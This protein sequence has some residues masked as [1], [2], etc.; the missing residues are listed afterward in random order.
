MSAEISYFGELFTGNKVTPAITKAANVAKTFG[1]ALV[2]ARTPV[3]TGELKS[4]WKAK[5]EGNG[6]RWLND[7]PY[8]GFVEL[9]TRKMA[10]RQMLTSSLIDIS[11]VFE[12]ELAKELGRTLGASVIAEMVGT[13]DQPT[14]GNRV[15]DNVPGGFS[16]RRGF[17]PKT[18]L[19]RKQKDIIGAAKPLLRRGGRP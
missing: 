2:S 1:L 9:G 12:Q 7:T 15:S 19:T 13:P 6:I 10:P 17:D 3:D 8:A 11:L 18:K 4:N 5:L 16:N 14:Y